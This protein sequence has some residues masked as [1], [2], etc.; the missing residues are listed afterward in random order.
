MS[1]VLPNSAR[2]GPRLLTAYRTG[3]VLTRRQ[4]IIAKCADCMNNYVDG[5]NDCGVRTCPLYPWM[6]YAGKGATA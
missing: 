4:A 3:I 6:P 1:N 2:G 5:R